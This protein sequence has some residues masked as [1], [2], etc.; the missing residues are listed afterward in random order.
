MSFFFSRV[1]VLSLFI[2]NTHFF[3]LYNNFNMFG[4]PGSNQPT[5]EQRKLQE[6]YAYDTLR[7]ASLIAAALWVTPI[8]FHYVK[9][10]F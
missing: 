2:V 5:E 10:Q 3:L 8:V 9:K 1:A 6:Q 4:G 7:T